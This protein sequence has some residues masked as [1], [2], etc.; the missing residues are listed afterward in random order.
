MAHKVLTNAY[1]LLNSVDLSDHVKQVTIT[2]GAEMV[3]DTTMSATARSRL[4]GLIDWSIQIEFANDYVAAEV[5]ATLFPLVGAAAFAIEL[6]A[7]AGAVSASNPKY[8]G[9]ALLESYQ[10]ISGAVGGL[11]MG[12]VTLQGKGALARATS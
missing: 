2:Y 10:P 7:D 1:V 9:N 4:P 12:P 6:R 11:A 3:D 5:D 8:T